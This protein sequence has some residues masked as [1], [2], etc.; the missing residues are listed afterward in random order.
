VVRAACAANGAGVLAEDPGDRREVLARPRQ[1]AVEQ[2]R[3]D[4]ER[5]V[6][7]HPG[8]LVA[9]ALE[10]LDERDVVVVV[11]AGGALVGVHKREVDAA[12]GGDAA[13]VERDGGK[14]AVPGRRVVL[15]RFPRVADGDQGPRRRGRARGRGSRATRAAGRR[16][17]P[18]TRARRRWWARGRRPGGRRKSPPP[19]WKMMC[20]TIPFG[21]WAANSVRRSVA[22]RSQSTCAQPIAVKAESQLHWCGYRRGPGRVAS[23]SQLPSSAAWAR[24]ASSTAP[25]IAQRC[26]PPGANPLPAPLLCAAA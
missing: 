10:A 9:V 14:G 22:A 3:D 6:L 13:R 23:P 26:T 20:G 15:A 2:R 5:A 25:T 7:A 8:L 19:S 11:R 21:H 4:P 1:H 17:R 18:G 24:R 12:I 16:G